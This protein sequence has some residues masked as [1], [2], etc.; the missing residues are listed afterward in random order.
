MTLNFLSIFQLA[1]KEFSKYILLCCLVL[2]AC[3]PSFAQNKKELEKKKQQL[4]RE[5][6]ETNKQLKETSKNKSLTA[7]QVNALKK[8]IR[9]RQELIGTINTELDGLDN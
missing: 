7:N 6:D 4:Q 3:A 2:A 5:I 1:M 8:K 9:L